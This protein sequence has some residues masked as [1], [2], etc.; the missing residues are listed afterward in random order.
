[1]KL[2]KDPILN[3]TEIFN[4]KNGLLIRTNILDKNGRETKVEPAMRSFPELIDIGIMGKCHVTQMFCKKFGV[5]CYQAN[6]NYEDMCLDDYKR[7]IDEC[8][9]INK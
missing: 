3:F 6:N 4:E 5:D 9:K 2:Y 8:K 7:I 1:M